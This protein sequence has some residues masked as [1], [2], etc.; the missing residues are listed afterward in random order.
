MF[1]P[2]CF[3]AK[4]GLL[5]SSPAVPAELQCIFQ[6]RTP[7]SC[8]VF[9][10]VTQRSRRQR[11]GS[12]ELTKHPALQQFEASEQPEAEPSSSSDQR[13]QQLLEQDSDS[14]KH[15]DFIVTAKDYSMSSKSAFGAPAPLQALSLSTEQQTSLVTHRERKLLRRQ[16]IAQQHSAYVEWIRCQL[17]IIK[18]CVWIVNQADSA[19]IT[20]LVLLSLYVNKT[21][22]LFLFHTCFF[23]LWATFCLPSTR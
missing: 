8:L 23:S 22:V 2:T 1:V 21:L 5:C 19:K 13:L 14:R 7:S 18:Y 11:G 12:Q 9:W 3:W 4:Q 10:A 17:C 6:S 20:Q 16:S 15:H